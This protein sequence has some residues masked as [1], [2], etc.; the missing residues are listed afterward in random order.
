MLEQLYT[1][2]Y[3][4][5]SGWVQIVPLSLINFTTH[6]ATSSCLDARKAQTISPSSPV[7]NVRPLKV[8]FDRQ[9]VLEG[10]NFR[11]GGCDN[12]LM[13]N[14]YKWKLMPCHQSNF[15]TPETWKKE[16]KKLMPNVK[17]N[18]WMEKCN[19]SVSPQYCSL[20]EN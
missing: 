20:P 18:S 6:P 17:S 2:L 8:S 16:K 10:L 15:T 4:H 9:F 14:G 11:D 1:V 5:C 13:V 19:V 12:I 3:E 7:D